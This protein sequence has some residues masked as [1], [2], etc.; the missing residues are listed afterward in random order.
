MPGSDAKMLIM[1]SD[2]VEWSQWN[3]ANK[4]PNEFVTNFGKR[5]PPKD[6]D[7]ATREESKESP[8]PNSF[9]ALESK[10]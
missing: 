2:E 5:I 3:S 7:D 9:G 8:A 6:F 10:L 1:I 4:V